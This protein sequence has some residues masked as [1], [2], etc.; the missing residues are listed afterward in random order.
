MK[1]PIIA[2][3]AT[4]TLA[5][6]IGVAS[7]AN[8][9]NVENL[10]TAGDAIDGE[11]QPFDGEGQPFVDAFAAD[12]RMRTSANR[13]PADCAHQLHGRGWSDDSR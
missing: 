11:K 1:L 3:I 13:Q 5:S 6:G 4:I 2:I 7:A 10:H 9:G 8:S 12:N